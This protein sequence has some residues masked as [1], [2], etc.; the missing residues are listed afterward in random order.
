MNS[1]RHPMRRGN[2]G[3]VKLNG[4]TLVELMVAITIMAILLAVATPSFNDVLLGSKL[5]SYTNS[6]VASTTLAR[7]EAIKR[8]D[9]VTLCV[10]INGTSCGAGTGGWEQGWIVLHGTTLIQRQA[11][12]ASGF[13]IIETGGLTTLTFQPTGVGATQA[14]LKVCRATPTVGKQER[15]I[16]I[17]ATGRASIQKT[18]NSSC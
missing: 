10:S 18:T 3:S 11:S 16:S 8:N 6:F 5:S 4:F 15:V 17:S 9:V 2:R 14:S 12:I 13:K 7:G 1:S